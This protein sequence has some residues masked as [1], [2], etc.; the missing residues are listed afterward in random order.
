M[1]N[2]YFKILVIAFLTMVSVCACSDKS[3]NTEIGKQVIE[4]KQEDSRIIYDPSVASTGWIAL[5]DRNKGMRCYM[6]V[7]DYRSIRSSNYS[8]RNKKLLDE[9]SNLVQLGFVVKFSGANLIWGFDQ[10]EGISWKDAQDYVNNYSPDGE[11]WRL[12]SKVEAS[13][14]RSNIHQFIGSFKEYYPNEI[15]YSGAYCSIQNW[16]SAQ[17]GDVWYCKKDEKYYNYIYTLDIY[18]DNC[19]IRRDRVD[20]EDELYYVYPISS[21]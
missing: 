2:N 21:L 5:Y 8:Y 19:E 6:S 10:I 1:S 15:W 11:K 3:K 16:T 9:Y 7:D 20:S 17:S 14:I 13:S 12:L 18:H 4:E